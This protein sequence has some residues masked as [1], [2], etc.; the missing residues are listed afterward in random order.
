MA[1]AAGASNNNVSSVP[2]GGNSKPLS[3]KACMIETLKAVAVGDAAR[4]GELIGD[5]RLSHSNLTNVYTVA[6]R[7][8]QRVIAESVLAELVR[9]GKPKE[10]PSDYDKGW[11]EIV[12]GFRKI[13]GPHFKADFSR[14]MEEVEAQTA[15]ED[16]KAAAASAGAGAAAADAT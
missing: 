11:D 1:A 15:A 8:D 6:N 5:A 9:R 3:S 2:S 16:R 14:M 10:E 7:L 13:S 12:T 4:V